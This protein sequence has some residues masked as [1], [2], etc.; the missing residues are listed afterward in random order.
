MA[1]CSLVTSTWLNTPIFVAV[2]V[3]S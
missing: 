1:M 2:S 3:S